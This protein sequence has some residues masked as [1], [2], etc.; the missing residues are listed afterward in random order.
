MTRNNT[1]SL[2][3]L[4]FLLISACGPD[5][6]FLRPALDT[7]A[8]HVKNGHSLLAQGKLDAAKNEFARA[9]HLDAGYAPAWVGIALIQGQRGDPD[10]G[11]ET[12][13]QARALAATPADVK[14]VEQGY[15]QLQRMKS[16]LQN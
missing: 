7:P 8:Q 5:T 16:A 1:L 12:L 13:D 2:L 9:R 15:Q 11:L 14:T 6:I 4:S 3:L 10:G